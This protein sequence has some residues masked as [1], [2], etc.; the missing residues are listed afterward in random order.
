M[1]GLIG[2]AGV[3]SKIHETDIAV[4]EKRETPTLIDGDLGDFA[5]LTAYR[6]VRAKD[7]QLGAISDALA[8]GQNLFPDRCDLRVQQGAF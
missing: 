6:D 4:W 8:L 5:P 2:E 7:E 3:V 1:N